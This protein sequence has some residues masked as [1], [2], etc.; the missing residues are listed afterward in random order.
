MRHTIFLLPLLGLSACVHLDLGSL[1][2]TQKF[3][4]QI[5]E[6]NDASAKIA[7][8]TVT[9][10]MSG[11]SGGFIEQ[12]GIVASTR[13]QLDMAAED[14]KVKAV[15]L[16]VSS[17]GGGVYPSLAVQREILRF[18]E[19]TKKPVI[20]FVPDVAASGGYMA[21]SA[22]DQI[23]VHPAGL[24]GGIGVIAALFDIS[25]LAEWA[26]V[27]VHVLKA[28]KY[29]DL[30]SPLRHLTDE[31]RQIFQGYLTYY[32]DQFKE[33]VVAARPALNGK[34]DPVAEGLVYTAKDAVANGLADAIGDVYAAHA[35][36][37][38][39]VGLDAARTNLVAYRRPGQYA[40]SVHLARSVDPTSARFALELSTPNGGPGVSFMYLW[41]WKQ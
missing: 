9:G 6:D 3:Q 32:Y 15:L 23:V 22:A 35:R 17:P 20:A 12:P 13:E 1:L 25:G 31:D 11:Q 24:V 34:I 8:I 27:E 40:G 18:K 4:E 14:P 28:G 5:I 37:A 26:K 7:L 2:S 19:K 36:A 38:S 10:V 30:G 16:E 29:K 21:I 39:A 41:S 33:V